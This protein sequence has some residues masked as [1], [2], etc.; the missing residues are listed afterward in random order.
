MQP[1][2]VFTINGL[3]VKFGHTVQSSS[4]EYSVVRFRSNGLDSPEIGH[5]VDLCYIVKTFKYL[6][7]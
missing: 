3:M 4:Q 7:I 2:Y 1:G 5:S 6:T